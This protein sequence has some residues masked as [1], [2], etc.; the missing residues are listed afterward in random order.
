MV[1]LEIDDL[2]TALHKLPKLFQH[3]EIVGE[4]DLAIPYPE[5]EQVAQDKECLRVPLNPARKRSSF[6]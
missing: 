2:G 5:L 4:G 1:S 3:R 6:R